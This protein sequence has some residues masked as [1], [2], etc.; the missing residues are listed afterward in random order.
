[1]E[2]SVEIGIKIIEIAHNDHLHTLFTFFKHRGGRKFKKWNGT[3][4]HYSYIMWNPQILRSFTFL[5]S[6]DIE[7]STTS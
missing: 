4:W 6:L 5:P 1:M 3:V 2:C 7:L